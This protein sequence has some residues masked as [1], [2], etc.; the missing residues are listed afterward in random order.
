MT[1]L[2][3]SIV[4]FVIISHLSELAIFN[5]HV[6]IKYKKHYF[7]KNGISTYCGKM[8]LCFD[9]FHKEDYPAT[10]LWQCE[11]WVRQ[12]TDE[13]RALQQKFLSK[14]ILVLSSSKYLCWVHRS[15]FRYCGEGF[16][17]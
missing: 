8:Q 10:V 4:S 3:L 13:L 11:L 1:I 9:T 7:I 17:W 16:R 14:K 2:G 5:L 12:L 6:F 15:T